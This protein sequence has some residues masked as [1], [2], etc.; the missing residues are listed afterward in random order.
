MIEPVELQDLWLAACAGGLVILSGALYALLFAWSRVH[1][2]PQLMPVAYGAYG[3]LALFV[4]ILAETLHLGGFWQIIVAVLLIGYLLAPHG[5]WHLCVG[6][7]GESEP[8]L[9]PSHQSPTPSGEQ[10]ND[11]KPLVG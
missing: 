4:A 1:S 11:D 9:V 6:T 2:K 5:I 3:L 7:H 10:R 8:T